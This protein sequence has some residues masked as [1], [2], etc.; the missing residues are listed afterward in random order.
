MEWKWDGI[1]AQL[2]RREWQT[3]LWSRGEELITDR[4]PEM[5]AVGALLPE[6]TVIDG[7]VMPWKDGAPAIRADAAAHR[8]QGACQKILAEVPAVLVAYDLLEKDG[9]DVRERP[10][11]WRRARLED[12]LRRMGRWCSRPW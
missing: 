7:E 3:F 4:F 2:I 8:A 1:R 12:W 11:E 5:A 9:E 6:G 10:L